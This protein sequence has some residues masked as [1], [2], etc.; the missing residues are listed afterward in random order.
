MHKADVV[1]GASIPVPL[2][3]CIPGIGC[4]TGPP[5]ISPARISV[6]LQRTRACGHVCCSQH[7]VRRDDDAGCGESTA[8]RR[9]EDLPDAVVRRR[10]R[11]VYIIRIEASFAN[12]DCG[13]LLGECYSSQCGNGRQFF[14]PHF[15][16]SSF[17]GG[18]LFNAKRGVNNL[19][20]VFK[21]S[22][23]DDITPPETSAKFEW[24]LDGK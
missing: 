24:A 10:I 2:R 3:V 16:S 22:R 18:I 1:A 14:S 15:N 21:M 19:Y 17:D 7:P 9:A 20:I 13:R 11:E 23:F 4:N 8:A 6:K 12:H 5:E